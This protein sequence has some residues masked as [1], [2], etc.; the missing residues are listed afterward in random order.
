MLTS[1]HIPIKTEA[2]TASLNH[3]FLYFSSKELPRARKI[4]SPDLGAQRFQVRAPL[5]F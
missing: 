1:R 3:F 5:Q 2:A 4:V